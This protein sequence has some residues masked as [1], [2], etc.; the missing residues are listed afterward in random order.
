[1]VV[2]ILERMSDTRADGTSRRPGDG[3]GAAIAIR[4][5]AATGVVARAPAQYESELMTSPPFR[6]PSSQ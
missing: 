3:P 5:A 2:G 1:M 6:L 4:E